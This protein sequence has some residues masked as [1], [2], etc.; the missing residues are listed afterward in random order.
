MK[1][2]T[3]L[4][5]KLGTGKAICCKIMYLFTE[6]TDIEEGSSIVVMGCQPEGLS[7]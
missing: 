3:I 4:F 7:V 6:K 2:G 1:Y 5:L